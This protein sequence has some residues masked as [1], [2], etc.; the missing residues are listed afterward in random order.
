ML[1]VCVHLVSCVTKVCPYGG[2]GYVCDKGICVLMKFSCVWRLRGLKSFGH[3][4]IS[5]GIQVTWVVRG[6]CV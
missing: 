3:K 1:C 4:G 6:V 5:Q 2:C